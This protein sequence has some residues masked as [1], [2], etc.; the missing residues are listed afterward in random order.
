M[1]FKWGNMGKAGLWESPSAS[2]DATGTRDAFAQADEREGGRRHSFFRIQGLFEAKFLCVSSV[3]PSGVR[4][5]N[6][7]CNQT[8]DLSLSLL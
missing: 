8:P 3:S 1:T 4:A 7:L 2:W 5:D 6:L